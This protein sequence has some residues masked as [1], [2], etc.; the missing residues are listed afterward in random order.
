[1]IPP[2]TSRAP[3]RRTGQVELAM[4]MA[5]LG[6]FAPALVSAV[7]AKPVVA[8]EMSI[9]QIRAALEASHARNGSGP[10]EA[11]VPF[12]AEQVQ[13]AHVPA[14]PNDGLVD[15]T[16]LARFLPIEHR[17]H[18]AAFAS[19]RMDL[20]FTVNGKDIVVKGAIRAKLHDGRELV[21]PV[22]I[23]YMVEHGKIIRFQIDAS[24]PEMQAGYRLQ[25][26][27]FQSP[28]ARAVYDEMRRAMTEKK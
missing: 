8:R 7:A 9:E 17:L 24:T 25:R 15:R 4:A 5:F 11:L 26:E 19:R 2:H 10:F 20:T 1:M 13:T 21:H 22:N 6:S 23:A 16:T 3:R 28:Q 27:A 18:E 14:F 12:L